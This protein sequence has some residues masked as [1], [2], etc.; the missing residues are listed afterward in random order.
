MSKRVYLASPFFND[1]EIERVAFVERV[2]RSKGLDV[3]SPR[4]HQIQE[5]EFGSKKWRDAVFA[6]DVTNIHKA[7]LVVAVCSKDEGTNWEIGYA[8]ANRIPIILFNESMTSLNLMISDSIHAY[9]SSRE[10]L[11][12]YDFEKMPHKRYEGAVI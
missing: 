5:L 6:N 2:L 7:D 12:A 1:E 9:I 4:E 8:Y 10:E 3:F 11:E